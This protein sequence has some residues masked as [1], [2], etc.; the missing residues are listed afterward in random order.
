[1]SDIRET[2]E[3]A[4]KT[5]IASDELIEAWGAF[6]RRIRHP[7]EY[8]GSGPYEC[9]TPGVLFDR[10]EKLHSLAEQLEITYFYDPGTKTDILRALSSRPA[11]P[12]AAM[13]NVSAETHVEAVYLVG[14]HIHDEITWLCGSMACSYDAIDRQPRFADDC[15][16]AADN[17]R[18]Y[19]RSG[20]VASNSLDYLRQAVA[21][22][23]LVCRT[24]F[25][26][27]LATIP[28]VKQSQPRDDSPTPV[29]LENG[30]QVLDKMA[31]KN[32]TRD[33]LRDAMRKAGFKI[34]T[35]KAGLILHEL[36]NLK[37]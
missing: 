22:E 5:M 13:L 24:Y 29:D 20:N 14:S 16:R 34:G 8:D 27:A 7:G 10:W 26:L 18:D 31:V 33:A 12:V 30:R 4:N 3:L 36:K 11:V 6:H 32:P 17:L 28:A 23:E 15:E 37:K 35:T 1:M 19:V 21:A 9:R 2:F 25:N